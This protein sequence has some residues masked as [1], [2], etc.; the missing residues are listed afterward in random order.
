MACARSCSTLHVRAIAAMPGADVR[1]DA[2][3]IFGA[4]VVVGDDDVV[5]E[6]RGDGAHQRALARVA[7]A[8]A[9]EHD[10]QAAAAMHARGAQRFAQRVGR[11]RVVDDR[12]RH[13]RAAAEGF[14]AAARRVALR[15]RLRGI[16]ERHVPGEQHGE[17]RR[18]RCRR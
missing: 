3:R 15:Q 4:R 10:V 11:V 18:A 8:A 9:A 6:L 12:E 2:A 14:H 16:V 17:H 1:D 13:G 5:R 7:I